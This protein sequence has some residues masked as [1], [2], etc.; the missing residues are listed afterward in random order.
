MKFKKCTARLPHNVT[1]DDDTTVL[2]KKLGRYEK[3]LGRNT[4]KFFNHNVAFEVSFTDF[5]EGKIT[6]LKFSSDATYHTTTVAATPVTSNPPAPVRKDNASEKPSQANKPST[7]NTTAQQKT[8]P[9]DAAPL[10]PFKRAILDVFKASK[11]SSFDSIKTDT[12]KESNFWKYKYTYNTK[13]KIPGE[14]YN[15]IYSFPFITSQLDFVVVL[16]EADTFEKSFDDLYRD[17]EKQLTINF[18]AAEGWIAT[19]LPGK[20]KTQLPDLEFRND[21]FGAIILDHSQNPSG[22][23]ILY[24]RFLLFSD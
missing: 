13:L 1:L 22:R 3:L 12:R 4:L 20:D 7:A 23:H 8:K 18:P 17:F 15:M 6:F 2:V 9:K 24:L 5:T 21:K 16:K 19:C 14:K 11:E 10:T